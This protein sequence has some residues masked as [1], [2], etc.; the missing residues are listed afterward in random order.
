MGVH[1]SSQFMRNEPFM[2]SFLEVGLGWHSHESVGVGDLDPRRATGP[3]TSTLASRPLLDTVSCSGSHSEGVCSLAHSDIWLMKY[4]ELN[5][6][7]G[8]DTG[9]SLFIVTQ[10]KVIETGTSAPFMSSSGENVL[11]GPPHLWHLLGTDLLSHFFSW[12]LHIK[13]FI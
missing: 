11:G 10:L 7:C 6:A 1:V 5:A 13:F 8:V 9:P 3:E 2:G 4:F 12:E